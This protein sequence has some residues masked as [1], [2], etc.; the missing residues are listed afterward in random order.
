MLDRERF[1]SDI[2]DSVYGLHSQAIVWQGL[3]PMA[4][5]WAATGRPHA[6]SRGSE[7]GS[8]P[9]RRACAAVRTSQP[10]LPDGSLFVP[11]R[12]LDPERPY[13][14]VTESRA[15]GYWNLVAPYAFASGL[16]PPHR[17]SRRTGF[18]ATCSC[19]DR[20]Y[21]GS[22]VPAP[23]RSTVDAGLS[24]VGCQSGVRAQRR[25]FLAD[26]DRPDQLVLS[27]Y[28]QLAAGMA[29]GTFVSGEGSRSRR[30]A[31]SHDRSMYLPPNGAS[32]GSFLE[33]LRLMLVHETS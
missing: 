12:L 24:D 8:P 6:G 10:T 32:N 22:S 17:A 21:W 5:V 30:C 2:K 11:M 18:C 4:P 14:S 1:S 29:P 15:G 26:N 31:A 20:A 23:T 19:T 27:L 9:R 16:F 13:E 3:A 25:S 33:T 28:G 7:A